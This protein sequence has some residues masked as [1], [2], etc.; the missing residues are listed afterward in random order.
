MIIAGINCLGI[1]LGT[2]LGVFTF[3][4]LLRPSVQHVFDTDQPY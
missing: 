4:V 2:T 1:P 3:I